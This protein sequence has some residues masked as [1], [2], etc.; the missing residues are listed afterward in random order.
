MRQQYKRTDFYAHLNVLGD[1]EVYLTEQY[2]ADF[3]TTVL[4]VPRYG[5][6]I[7]QLING[8]ATIEYQRPNLKLLMCLTVDTRYLKKEA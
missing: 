8:E 7:K 4:E 2:Y 1:Q 3:K 6:K 5:W